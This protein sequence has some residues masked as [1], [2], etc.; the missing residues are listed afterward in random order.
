FPERPVVCTI[1]DGAFQMLGMND[2]LTVKRHWQEWADPR[3]IVLVLHND[4][5]NQ[6]S[7]ELREAGDPRWDVSQLVE[8]M[9]Y[10]A[11]A[12][13]L[14]LTGLRLDDPDAVD[15]VWQKAFA[16]D[17]PVL[18][19]ARTDKNVPP[20]PPHITLEQTTG[21]AKAVL[22]SDPDAGKVVGRT[23]RTLAAQLFARFGSP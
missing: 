5:L 2:L 14:G 1:G 19:D 7:W 13:L 22:A 4:D 18:V 15:G 20:L 21:V 11:Y 17:R 3:F 16:A 12:E 8:D 6:V 10:A 23:A 9:D